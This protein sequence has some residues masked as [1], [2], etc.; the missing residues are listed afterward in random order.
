MLHVLPAASVV[1]QVVVSL[2]A[3]EVAPPPMLMEMPVRVALPVFDSVTGCAAATAGRF[4]V[5]VSDDAVSPAMGA[6]TAVPVPLRVTVCGEPAAL[7]ETVM[8]ELSMATDLGV[9]AIVKLQLAPGA[10]DAPQVVVSLKSV[11][12]E[13]V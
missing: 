12:S 3:D 4:V 13:T 9:N 7:S 10:S 8:I 2:N 5:K 1:P 6:G 11:V